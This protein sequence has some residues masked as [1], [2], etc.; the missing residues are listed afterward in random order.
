ML[1][2]FVLSLTPENCFF[3]MSSYPRA[4]VCITYKKTKANSQTNISS[5]V[6]GIKAKHTSK[7]LVRVVLF[8]LLLIKNSNFYPLILTLSVLKVGNVKNSQKFKISFVENP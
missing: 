8:G 5:P 2:P 6:I 1:R 4:F 7:R 3:E